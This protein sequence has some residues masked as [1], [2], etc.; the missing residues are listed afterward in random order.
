MSDPVSCGRQTRVGSA[1]AVMRRERRADAQLLLPP[2]HRPGRSNAT[3]HACSSL[4]GPARGTARPGSRRTTRW[5]PRGARGSRRARAAPSGRRLSRTRVRPRPARSKR[6]TARS[7]F[8]ENAPNCHARGSRIGGDR[9]VRRSRAGR[10]DDPR[11]SAST[12]VPAAGRV[13]VA[14]DIARPLARLRTYLRASSGSEAK[15]AKNAK[16]T[17]QRV[18]QAKIRTETGSFAARRALA[19][20]PKSSPR[21]H[22]M[23][24]RWFCFWSSREPLEHYERNP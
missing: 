21:L 24:I 5:A 23:P 14:I 12:R 13:A 17:N 4:A 3:S 6:A 10:L 1:S 9:A 15:K 20:A 8:A 22:E 2:H 19:N 11:S 7:A 16:R 18:A